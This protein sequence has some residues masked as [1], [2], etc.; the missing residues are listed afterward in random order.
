[1]HIKHAQSGR[2]RDKGLVPCQALDRDVG[3][4]EIS[5]VLEDSHRDV[6]LAVLNI[7]WKSIAQVQ[8]PESRLTYTG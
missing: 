4:G 7:A 2:L 6:D 1:M 8:S 5:D 3:E